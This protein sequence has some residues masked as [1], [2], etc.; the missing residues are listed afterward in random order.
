MAN[1]TIV[2]YTSDNG[3]YCGSH[4]LGE[5][6]LSHEESARIPLIIYDPR[7]EA[8]A[9]GG[10]CRRLASSI[11]Y[12]PTIMDLAGLE[13]DGAADGRSLRP[14]L[15]NPETKFRR[16]LPLVYNWGWTENDHHRGMAVVT[17]EWKYIYWCYGDHNMEPAEELYHLAEDPC[18]M[19]NMADDPEQCEALE[20]MRE[21]YDFHHRE[22]C[23][24][25]VE[26]DDY[27]RLRKLF[28]RHVSW[29][30]KEY[31]GFRFAPDKCGKAQVFPYTGGR[32]DIS[33]VVLEKIYQELTGEKNG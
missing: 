14:L 32:S 33:Y 5:K 10:R 16:S 18:E 8:D 26:G 2:I 29:R 17:E 19:N 30:E 15:E 1:N 25:C 21:I 31:R 20:E 24:R 23:E 12:A 3:Y 6:V 11:D 9:G 27:R 4:G 28:D 7:I 22:L 13:P